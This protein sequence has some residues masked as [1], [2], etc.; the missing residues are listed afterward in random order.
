[1]EN[2]N[3][4]KNNLIYFF[5]LYFL[6]NVMEKVCIILYFRIVNIN[7]VIFV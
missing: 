2:K 4:F 3:N 5:Y 6:N 7:I 1:M